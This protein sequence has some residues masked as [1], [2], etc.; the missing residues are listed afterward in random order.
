MAA[1]KI[2]TYIKGVSRIFRLESFTADDRPLF[3]RLVYNNAVMSMN[4]GRTFTE[5]EADFFFGMILDGAARDDVFR[6]CK[7]YLSDGG[8]FIGTCSLGLNEEYDAA[9]IEYMLLPEFWRKGYGTALASELTALAEKHTGSTRAVAII[10][11]DNVFSRRIL[12]KLGF[13]SEKVYTNPDGGES[14]LMLK[15]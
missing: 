13:V 14:E 3:E 12:E 10:A 15:S 2:V 4:M 7:V 8:E 1:N 6:Y 9:E 11:P 5:E